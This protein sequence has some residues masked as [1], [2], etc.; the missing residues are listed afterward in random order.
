MIAAH[1]C[2]HNIE[3]S[4]RNN[5]GPHIWVVHIYFR[6]SRNNQNPH[7]NDY[8]RHLRQNILSHLIRDK[9]DY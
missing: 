5:P 7:D 8:M 1:L 4:I 2:R 9:G 6:K 3:N